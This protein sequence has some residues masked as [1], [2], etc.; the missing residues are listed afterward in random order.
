MLNIS[1]SD[2]SDADPDAGSGLIKKQSADEKQALTAKLQ[3]VKDVFNIAYP[4]LVQVKKEK[5]KKGGKGKGA[6]K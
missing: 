5:K 3:Q 1:D 2:D 6:K 4:H